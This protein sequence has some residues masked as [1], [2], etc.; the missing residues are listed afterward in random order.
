MIGSR[1]LTVLLLAG[2]AGIALAVLGWSQRYTGLVAHAVGGLGSASAP[3]V[4]AGS[5]QSV[6]PAA[7]PS[8]AAAVPQAGPSAASSAPAS[9]GPL[10]SSEP[11]AQYAYLEWPGTPSVAARQAASGLTISVTRQAGGIAVRAGVAGQPTGPAHFYANGR[12]VYVIESSLGDDTAGVDYN[13]GD[14]GL[15]VTDAH[16]RILQ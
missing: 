9:P 13:L 2:L 4:P 8:S 1:G 16:G 12:G 14:D 5:P 3:A 11:Y 7:S 15:V 10:L 6:T